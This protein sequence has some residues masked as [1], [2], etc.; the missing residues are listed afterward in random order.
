VVDLNCN[1][2]KDRMEKISEN[3]KKVN[4]SQIAGDKVV[5][6]L[7]FLGVVST[8]N[9]LWKPLSNLLSAPKT[10]TS[11]T[12]ERKMLDKYSGGWALIINGDDD[13]GIKIAKRL[14]Y[15]GFNILMIV[16]PSTDISALSQSIDFS[17]D[18][19]SL[20]IK[21]FDGYKLETLEDLN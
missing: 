5:I 18:S 10:K 12:S 11:M 6:C 21:V 7:A 1:I 17:S 4:L 15:E 19:A 3:L 2:N 8:V 13:F 20:E 14:A 16:K 9:Y